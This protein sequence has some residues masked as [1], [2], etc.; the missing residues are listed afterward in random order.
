MYAYPEDFKRRF[1]FEYHDREMLKGLWYY[2]DLYR[3]G[4]KD[5]YDRKVDAM[6]S[7]CGKLKK[8]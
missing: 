7:K 4:R 6:L 8:G 1:P 2:D 5:E 3:H